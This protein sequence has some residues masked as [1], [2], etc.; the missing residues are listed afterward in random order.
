MG[1]IGL[2]AVSVLLLVLSPGPATGDDPLYGRVTTV[3][4][5]TTEGF[6]RWDRNEASRADYLDGRKEIATEHLVEAERLDPAF[7]ARQREARSIVAFGMRITWDEDDQSDPPAARSAVRFGLL[8]SLVPLDARRAR[9]TLV[10]GDTLTFRSESTDLGTGLRELIVT[11]ADGTEHDF[12][13]RS[14]ERV[15]F[16]APPAGV[17]P[18]D[19]RR[20][21]GTLSTWD[22]QEFVGAVSWDLDESLESDILD[23]RSRGEDHEIPFARIAAIEWE[24][25][26]SARV[27]LKDG[28]EL[29]LRGTNDVDRSNR[30]IEVADPRFGRA[31]VPWEDFR[32][33]RFH[34]PVQARRDARRP[35]YAS[36]GRGSLRG[37]VYAADGRVLEGRL[38]WNN[39]QEHVW[40]ALRGWVGETRIDV[41][42]GSIVELRK[43][44]EARVGVRLRSD[45]TLELAIDTTEDPVYGS[46][47][48]YVTPEGR[49]TRLVLW[50]DLDRVELA[51]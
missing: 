25:D 51:R 4:G 46:R 48:M 8:R 18:P 32:E 9:L 13:W 40:E 14:V 37:T 39:E 17:S 31:L 36:D 26:R 19:P 21:H 45:E 49:P 43:A 11:E 27:R 47:G 12:R 28:G 34:A 7:A 6:I 30:G 10:S 42:F 50:R 5:D 29:V 44:G 3:D 24:S 23:G 2:R 35:P 33:I 38:R 20:L 1:P 15:D 41:E 22:G 16:T